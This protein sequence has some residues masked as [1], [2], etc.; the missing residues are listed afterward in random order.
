MLAYLVFRFIQ[1]LKIKIVINRGF[2]LPKF[3]EPDLAQ[4]ILFANYLFMP[5]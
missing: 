4:A 1:K 5:H 2:V 3:L